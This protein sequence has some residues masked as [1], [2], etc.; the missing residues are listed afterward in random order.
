ML[1]LT[2]RDQLNVVSPLV[3]FFVFITIMALDGCH[4]DDVSES[5]M[6][7]IKYT[8]LNDVIELTYKHSGI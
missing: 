5:L 4:L 6:A 3:P 7:D 8:Y 2:H 1:L